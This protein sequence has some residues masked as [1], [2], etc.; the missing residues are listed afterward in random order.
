MYGRHSGWR[1]CSDGSN[2]GVTNAVVVSSLAAKGVLH[3]EKVSRP[4]GFIYFFFCSW[5]KGLKELL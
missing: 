4:I 1:G 3:W 2:E 5:S